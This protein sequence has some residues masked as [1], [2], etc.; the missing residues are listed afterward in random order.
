MVTQMMLPAGESNEAIDPSCGTW[1]KPWSG[2]VQAHWLEAMM[3]IALSK[4][5]IEGVVW[6]EIVDHPS[7]ELPLAGLMAEDL[8]PKHAFKRLAAFRQAL[9]SEAPLSPTLGATAAQMPEG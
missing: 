4:P 1:R 7:I 9:Q 6:Q 8:S 2:H 5:Y 3:H